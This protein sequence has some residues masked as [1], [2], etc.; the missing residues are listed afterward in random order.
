[1]GREGKPKLRFDN[2]FWF[3]IFDLHQK[4]IFSKELL[5][6]S[7]LGKEEKSKNSKKILKNVLESK[8]NFLKQSHLT[9]AYVLKMPQYPWGWH[10]GRLEPESKNNFFFMFPPNSTMIQFINSKLNSF[11]LSLKWYI[12]VFVHLSYLRRM[13]DQSRCTGIKTNS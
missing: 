1:M 9:S 2:F 3:E 7:T 4:D 11:H 12:T 10:S 5:Q 13:T 6:M 8:I